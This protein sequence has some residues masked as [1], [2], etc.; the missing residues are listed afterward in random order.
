M[1]YVLL[2]VVIV[3][4]SCKVYD[5]TNCRLSKGY[6]LN[7]SLTELSNKGIQTE[8]DIC[9]DIVHLSVLKSNLVKSIPDL[10]SS[11]NLCILDAGG[12]KGEIALWLAEMGHKI[13]LCDLSDRT[14]DHNTQNHSKNSVCQ[15]IEHINSPLEKLPRVFSAG[16]FDIIFLHGVIEWVKSPLSV[17]QLLSPLLKNNGILSLLYLNKDKQILKWGINGQYEQAISGENKTSKTI[18]PLNPLSEYE[19]LPLLRKLGFKDITKSGINIFCDLFAKIN[20]QRPSIAEA[21][22]LED[23]YSRSEPFASLGKH[24][25][26]TCRK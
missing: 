2:S 18:T 23:I 14:Q 1:T 20:Q 17:I 4:T 9:E 10:T 11:N 6:I 12:G 13:K 19:V 16:Q 8:H 3:H 25:H 7:A 21:I 22:K 26:Y 24:T 15:N 5:I